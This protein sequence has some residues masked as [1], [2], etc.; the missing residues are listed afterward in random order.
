MS[1]GLFLDTMKVKNPKLK[2]NYNRDRYSWSRLTWLDY[3]YNGND[4][5]G[6]YQALKKYI[7][8]VNNDNIIT[9]PLTSTGYVRR[10]IKEV[11]NLALTN[12]KVNGAI[13]FCADMNKKDK[14]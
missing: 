6:L 12:E 5:I 7:F 3:R 8:E 2:Y 11:L 9:T 1:L 10:D 4:V 14:K 13:D